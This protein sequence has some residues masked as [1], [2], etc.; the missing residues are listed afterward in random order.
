MGVQDLRDVRCPPR[1]AGARARGRYSVVC[2]PRLRL[3]ESQGFWLGRAAGSPEGWSRRCPTRAAWRIVAARKECARGAAYCTGLVGPLKP[4]AHEAPQQRRG[5]NYADSR[6][7]LPGRSGTTRNIRRVQLARSRGVTENNA[8]RCSSMAWSNT[9][10]LASR[11][12]VGR[13]TP[14]SSQ[15]T[16]RRSE[17]GS[18]FGSIRV[19]PRHDETPAR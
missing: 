13:R 2:R 18:C 5:E 8:A 15:M 17:S 1:R 14:Q 16:T 9:S 7:G 3:S 4:R 11:L 19:T 6:S 12:G 10:R